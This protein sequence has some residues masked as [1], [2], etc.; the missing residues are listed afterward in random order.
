L[1]VANASSHNP[2]GAWQLERSGTSWNPPF[3]ALIKAVI[4]VA[5]VV[6]MVQ[7][8]LHV[9]HAIRHLRDADG[10]GR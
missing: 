8:V 5:C 9:V 7:T 2:S 6:M 4:L 1:P 10:G 3:P